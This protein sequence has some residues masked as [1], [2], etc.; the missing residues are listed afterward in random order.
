MECGLHGVP[1]AHAPLPVNQQPQRYQA[2]K[3]EPGPVQIRPQRMMGNSAPEPEVRPCLVHR[4][5]PV[6]VMK[7]SS[8][9]YLIRKHFA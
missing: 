6:E 5:T 3:L 2:L 4:Q 7:T 8:D 9:L 1:T